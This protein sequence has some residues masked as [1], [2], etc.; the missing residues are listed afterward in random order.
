MEEMKE[1]T[2]APKINE[3]SNLILKNNRKPNV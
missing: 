3:K 1:C 2:Y